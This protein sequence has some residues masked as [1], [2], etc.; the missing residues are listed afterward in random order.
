VDAH[1]FVRV[2]QVAL[3][4]ARTDAEAVVLESGMIFALEPLIWIRGVQG[5]GG[6]RLE[7]TVLV[8]PGG[9]RPVTRTGLDEKLL[10]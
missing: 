3:Y 6:V 8:T 2:L 10:V 1:V 4:G 7:D 5:G 9:G